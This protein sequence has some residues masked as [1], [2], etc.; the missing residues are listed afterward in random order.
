M[1]QDFAK[2]EFHMAR[3]VRNEGAISYEI[4]QIC[5]RFE[6]EKDNC[7]QREGGLD[8]N[9]HDDYN[10]SQMLGTLTFYKHTYIYDTRE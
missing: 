2:N 4:G 5:H 10:T 6:K 8:Y 7:E 3:N 1:E 9:C